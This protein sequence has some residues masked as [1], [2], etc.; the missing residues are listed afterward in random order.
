MFKIAGIF[1]VGILLFSAVCSTILADFR[2]YSTPQEPASSKLPEIEAKE[3][4]GIILTPLSQQTK[5]GKPQHINKATYKLKVTGLVNRELE[6]SY[7]DI[8]RLPAYS[9]VE[10]IFCVDG[11]N[12]TAKFTGFRMM[13]LF[14]LSE[15]KPTARSAVFYSSD[16]YSK[17][18]PL[19]YIINEQ[20]LAAYGI[21]D[22]TIPDDSGFPLQIVAEGRPGLD[23][24]KWVTRIDING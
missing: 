8:L 16:G 2:G 12:F 1:L 19:D 21:N 11:W 17:T 7:D 9:K 13:D 6:M 22:V 3:Y 5:T 15:P 20:I 14:N 10:Q 24:S 4:K 23:W 18:L